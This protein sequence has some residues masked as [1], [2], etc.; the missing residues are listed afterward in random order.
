MKRIAG[1]VFV[2][3]LSASTA[4]AQSA[5]PSKDTGVGG[6]G[7]FSG[8]LSDYQS[9]HQGRISRKAYMDEVGRRWDLTDKDKRGLTVDQINQAYGTGG[10]S[11]V[12]NTA[13]G[14]MG[15]NDVKK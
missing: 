5:A 13:P 6:S 2:A 3:A 7:T 8:W 1:A 4:F 9:Q 15:P 12:V 11:G 10:A 14:N